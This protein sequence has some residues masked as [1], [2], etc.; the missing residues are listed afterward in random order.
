MVRALR[1]FNTW[2][3]K[4]FVGARGYTVYADGR[5]HRGMAQI[6]ET[7]PV[8]LGSFRK[9]FGEAADLEGAHFF[10][11]SG[12]GTHSGLSGGFGRH[13]GHLV[14]TAEF[15]W[16]RAGL[17]TSMLWVW[18]CLL[19]A[20]LDI[21]SGGIALAQGNLTSGDA[22]VI[23]ITLVTLVLLMFLPRVIAELKEKLLYGAR[24]PVIAKL[25]ALVQHEGCG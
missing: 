25:S 12:P 7:A 9:M 11:P 14:A 6:V 20:G 17:N 8:Q 22:T 15:V 19:S 10:I 5:M 1:T 4:T 21:L 3:D 16:N 24:Q 18:L 2:L 23:G 13:E